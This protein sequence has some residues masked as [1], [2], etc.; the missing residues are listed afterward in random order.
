MIGTGLKDHGGD[1]ADE[2][3]HATASVNIKQANV[4]MS[5]P[6]FGG[7]TCQHLGELLK[8]PAPRWEVRLRFRAAHM[9]PRRSAT[10]TASASAS[11]SASAG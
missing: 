4:S 3:E 7:L 9:A 1:A 2:A 8:E 6:A 5:R 11:A 10:A